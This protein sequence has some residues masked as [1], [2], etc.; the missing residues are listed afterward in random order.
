MTANAIGGF[1]QRTD[2][3]RKWAFG[4]QDVRDTS[5][6]LFVLHSAFALYG[7]DFLTQLLLN[8]DVCMS[9]IM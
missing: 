9:I 2:E 7:W 6:V 3:I 1:Q 4:V 5:Y 8:L